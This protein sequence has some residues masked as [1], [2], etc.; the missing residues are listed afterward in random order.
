MA[1]HEPLVIVGYAVH[2]Y[3]NNG[4]VLQCTGCPAVTSVITRY[5]ISVLITLLVAVFH[6]LTCVLSLCNFM[7]TENLRHFAM[8]ITFCCQSINIRVIIMCVKGIF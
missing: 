2:K 1:D 6:V 5:R 7:V 8:D 4:Y 3:I